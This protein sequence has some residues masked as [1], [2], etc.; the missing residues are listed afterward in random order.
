MQYLQSEARERSGIS[1]EVAARIDNANLY[2]KLGP[3][4]LRAVSEAFYDAVFKR[5]GWFREIF[6]NVEKEEAV[7]N[8]YLFLVEKLGGPRIYTA[9]KGRAA[10]IGRHG[11][12]RVSDASAKEWLNCMEEGLCSVPGVD[13]ESHEVLMNYFRHMAFYLSAGMNLVNKHRL[14]GY[15]NKPGGFHGGGA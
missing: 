6:A 13:P 10:L 15:G 2:E 14:V 7:R 12:Y 3:A 9:K 5:E 11:P 1:A 8:Q 4:T